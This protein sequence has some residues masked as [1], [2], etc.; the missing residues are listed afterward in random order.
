MPPTFISKQDCCGRRRPNA[1]Y[2][3]WNNGEQFLEEKGLGANLFYGYRECGEDTSNIISVCQE[4][5]I[6][7]GLKW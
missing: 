4:C 5:V 7:L 3:Y 1:L 2:Y 6:R